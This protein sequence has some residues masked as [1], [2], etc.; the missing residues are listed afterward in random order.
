M[1]SAHV[2]VHDGGPGV[3]GPGIPHSGIAVIA[4]QC[5]GMLL[6]SY[7]LLH[8]YDAP[9]NGLVYPLRFTALCSCPICEA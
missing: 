4:K 5:N 9:Q 8:D 1:H 3:G 7:V 2:E 6:H